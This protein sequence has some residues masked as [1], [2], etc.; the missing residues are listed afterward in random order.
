M[1]HYQGITIWFDDV[2]WWLVLVM[3]HYQAVTIKQQLQNLL[4]Q[5]LGSVTQ[6]M[7]GLLCASFQG[8]LIVRLAKVM[9]TSVCYG[10]L[11][12]DIDALYEA[13]K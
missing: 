3:S 1:S 7:R 5:Q 10:Q 12:E 4:V 8:L 2:P 6:N 11:S 9:T 13:C